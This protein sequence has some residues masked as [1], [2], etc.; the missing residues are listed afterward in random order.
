MPTMRKAAGPRVLVEETNPY[1]S[2][3]LRVTFDGATT[4]ATLTS[5]RD[6]TVAAVWIANHAPAPQSVDLGRLNAGLAPLMPVGNTSAPQGS[7]PLD[8]QTLRVVWFEEGDGAAILDAAGPLAVLPGWSDPDAG[9][10]GYSRDAIGRTPFAWSLTEALEGLGPRIEQSTSYWQWRRGDNAWGGFQQAALGHLLQRLGP[11]GGYWDTGRERLPLVGITE[12]PPSPVRPYT[13]LSTVGMSC[14]RMPVIEQLVDE[15]TGYAR[16]ELALATTQPSQEAARVFLW[17]AQYPWRSVTWFGA[18][19]SVK[20]YHDTS[21]FPLGGGYS[22]VLLLDEPEK[23]TGP[24]PP[25]LSGFTFSGDPVTWLWVVPINEQDRQL[26]RERGS[27]G[28]VT[29]LTAQGRSWIS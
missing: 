1:G 2:R 14:Q 5:E 25:D 7:P 29:R 10:P 21:T 22:G 3:T 17:L 18:G 8:P 4:T 16:V 13:V 6:V 24:Q 26:A 12:R 20:W 27:A 28:L 19:H 15:P 9:M 23:L 11:G